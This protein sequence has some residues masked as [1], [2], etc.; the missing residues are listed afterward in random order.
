MDSGEPLISILL[1]HNEHFAHALEAVATRVSL[2]EEESA[3][4]AKRKAAELNV[5]MDLFENIMGRLETEPLIST[6]HEQSERILQVMEA[7]TARV[8]LLEDEL[9]RNAKLRTEELGH[10]QKI[11]ERIEA[12]T[13]KKEELEAKLSRLEAQEKKTTDV[14]QVKPLTSTVPAKVA[15]QRKKDVSNMSHG[16]ASP[17]TSKEMN[18]SVIVAKRKKKMSP[19][20]AIRSL[21]KKIE[22]VKKGSSKAKGNK[23]KEVDQAN[24]QTSKGSE[25]SIDQRI[26]A[27]PSSNVEVKKKENEAMEQVDPQVQQCK[28]VFVD[29]RVVPVVVESQFAQRTKTSTAPEKASEERRKDVLPTVTSIRDCSSAAEMNKPAPRPNQKKSV[30]T[31]NTTITPVMSLSETVNRGKLSASITDQ[32]VPPVVVES[33]FAQRT[34]TSTAPEKASE[35]RKKD[36]L[37]TITK[38]RDGSS[39]VEMNKP[40][41]R[42]N[43]NKSVST[44]N[45]AATPVKSLSGT[46]NRGKLPASIKDQRVP[47]VAIESQFSQRTK[48][49]TKEVSGTR[50]SRRRRRKAY[51]L[52]QQSGEYDREFQ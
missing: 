37:P 21:M 23:K 42:A 12:E 8:S 28:E 25:K 11:M 43:Q 15:V 22:S 46:V 19:S 41:P 50:K 3:G 13:T 31:V 33:Q 9:T 38:I 51:L 6:L 44:V 20:S 49:S 29:Q 39:A 18:K 26:K 7:V 36:V 34:K 47:P 5:F 24:P 17:G 14:V 35:E 16:F 40:T 1:K 45:T 48:T 30:S 52:Q 32:R 2:L 10:F 27:V 4:N